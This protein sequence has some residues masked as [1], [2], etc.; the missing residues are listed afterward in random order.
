[1][2]S[3]KASFVSVL[4][5]FLTQITSATT[6]TSHIHY[7]FNFLYFFALAS[8]T[9]GF[10]FQLQYTTMFNFFIRKDARK[11]LKRKDSDAGEKGTLFSFFY[12]PFWWFCL[13]LDLSVCLCL[14]LGYF[15]HLGF[16]FYFFNF[17]FYGYGNV[18]F[19]DLWNLFFVLWSF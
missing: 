18:L 19:I 11:I 2:N 15:C 10:C 9:L 17:L 14:H 5:F 8:S 3:T 6:H 7:S 4:L 1:L 12:I 13:D 16:Y